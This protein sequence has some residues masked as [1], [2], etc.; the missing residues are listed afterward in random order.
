M[1]SFTAM[2]ADLTRYIDNLEE[3]TAS[4]SRLEGELAA[5]REIQMAMLPQGGEA[6]DDC[7][8]Y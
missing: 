7:E 8:Q 5:A 1:R 3:A 4:R 2:Q 6:C